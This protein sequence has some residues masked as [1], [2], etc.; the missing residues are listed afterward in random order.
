MADRTYKM[1]E[2][3]GVSDKSYADATRNAVAKA[4][5]TLEGLAWFEVEEMRGVIDGGNVTE[6]QVKLKVGFRL[7]DREAAEIPQV[8]VPTRRRVRSIRRRA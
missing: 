1:I 4:A 6:F 5:Q 7:L 2:L 8:E 3:V